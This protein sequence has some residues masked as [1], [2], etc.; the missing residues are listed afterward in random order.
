[1]HIVYNQYIVLSTVMGIL[2]TFVVTG[3]KIN[4]LSGCHF[5]HNGVYIFLIGLSQLTDLCLLITAKMVKCN[6][7]GM[8]EVV[9]S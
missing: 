2:R 4:Q 1:M 9:F 3:D 5:C 8:S 7:L 6:S